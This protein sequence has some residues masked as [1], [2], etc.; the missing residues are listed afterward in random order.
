MFSVFGF[1]FTSLSLAVYLETFGTC[2]VDEEK[3]EKLLPE[4]MDLSPKGIRTHLN[5]NR[6]IYTPTSSYGHFGRTPGVD[7]AF[8]WEQTDLVDVLRK[9]M[10]L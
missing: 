2:H 8:P 7:G 1:F 4:V 5:L 3:L 9:E 10:G 6:P